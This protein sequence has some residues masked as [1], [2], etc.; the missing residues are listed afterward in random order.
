[1]TSASRLTRLL[2][3]IN[4]PVAQPWR[5]PSPHGESLR[6][7]A[8][9][10]PWRDFYDGD[11]APRRHASPFGDTYQPLATSIAV[12]RHIFSIWRQASQRRDGRENL[13]T[14]CCPMLYLCC[15][16]DGYRDV[17]SA[18]LSRFGDPC[19]R[20]AICVAVPQQL[21]PFHDSCRATA[22]HLVVQCKLSRPISPFRDRR[23]T[24]I[25]AATAVA[26]VVQQ[27]RCL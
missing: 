9:P 7:M 17:I 22:R 12:W 14:F 25:L 21:S 27:A 6:A 24:A 1:M 20:S 26:K 10:S 23:E 4:G 15:P 5:Q 19:R 16:R 13:I 3:I 11:I 8:K 18:G 2:H